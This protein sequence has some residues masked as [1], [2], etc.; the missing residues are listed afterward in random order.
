MHII[1]NAIAVLQP[2]IGNAIYLKRIRDLPNISYSTLS[3]SYTPIN[4]DQITPDDA[5][6]IVDDNSSIF[7]GDVYTEKNV[8]NIWALQWN[9]Y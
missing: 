9:S 5:A 8:L 4:V 6:P 3:L 1:D 2:W 7:D